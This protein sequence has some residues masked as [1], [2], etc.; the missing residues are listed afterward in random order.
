MITLKLRNNNFSLYPQK[1]IFWEEQSVLIISDVH[2]GKT[3]AFRS[4]GIPVPGG[5]TTDDLQ[6]LSHLIK[7]TNPKE[8]IILGDLI[9]SNIENKEK[10]LNAVKLWRVENE[11]IN[12]TLIK[13]NHD[14]A[15]D[16]FFER[17]RINIEDKSKE[18]DEFVFI[19]D[20]KEVKEEKFVFAGHIHPAVRLAGKGGIREQVPCFYFSNDFAILPSFGSFTGNF[21]IK[22]KDFEKVFVIA[23]EEI[24][25]VSNK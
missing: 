2:I 5:L 22:P 12:V 24:I 23:G 19:H 25:E 21:I 20:P 11:A 9:H 6:R 3:A 15:D 4:V 8:L 10:T 1:G 13:G 17:L 18:M 7:L 16:P 14:K